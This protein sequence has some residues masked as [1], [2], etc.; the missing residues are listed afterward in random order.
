MAK[1]VSGTGGTTATNPLAVVVE[2]FLEVGPGAAPPTPPDPSAG[3]VAGVWGYVGLAGDAPAQT[4]QPPISCGVFGEVD[5]SRGFLGVEGHPYAGYAGVVGESGFNGTMT[6]PDTNGDGVMGFGGGNGVRGFT[7][8]GTGVAGT[9]TDGAGVTGTSRKGAGVTGTSTSGAGVVGTSSSGSNAG[10]SGTNTSNNP[11]GGP[12]VFGQSTGWDGVHGES[13]S[14]QHAGV[15]GVNTGKGPGV[16][17][18]GSPAGYFS[19]DVQV[20]GDVILI[21]SSGDVAEDFDVE[22][23]AVHE[24]AGTVLVINSSGKLCSSVTPY[25]TRVAGVVAGAGDL[26][27]AIVL[28]RLE[29]QRGRSPIALIGKA[30]CK[31]D[32]SFGSINAGDLLTTSSTPG[33]A[34]KVLDCAK[35]TGAILG[36]ALRGLENGQGLIPILVTPH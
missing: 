9:S 22:D 36:K 32:A 16:W 18:S 26:K 19:G 28:Q 20:T 21:N 6:D 24:E 5:F 15:S 34:M 35:A 23:G 2:G 33:H 17:A 25:D 13:Q 29:G 31:V 27:P 14:N 1:P 12:G 4:S 3:K 11:N 7:T 10:V 30:F 8:G